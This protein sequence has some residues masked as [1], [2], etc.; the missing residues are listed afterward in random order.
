MTSEYNK[1]LSIYNK[2]S[3]FTQNYIDS[4]KSI[5]GKTELDQILGVNFIP[6]HQSE[7]IMGISTKIIEINEVESFALPI[8]VYNSRLWRGTFTKFHQLLYDHICMIKYAKQEKS[9][10]YVMDMNMNKHSDLD[11]AEI[12]GNTIYNTLLLYFR[13]GDINLAIIVIQLMRT[14]LFLITDF[15]NRLA[16]HQQRIIFKNKFK[17]LINKNIDINLFK[18]NFNPCDWYW[19]IYTLLSEDD[20]LILPLN[21]WDIIMGMITQPF[22]GK[23]CFT[24]DN[25]E[26]KLLKILL[27]NCFSYLSKINI[28]H[29]YTTKILIETIYTNCGEKFENHFVQNAFIIEILRNIFINPY[30]IKLCYGECVCLNIIL[31]NISY[32]RTI[33]TNLHGINTLN[34]ALS[35]NH[36]NKLSEKTFV[37]LVLQYFYSNSDKKKINFSM[38]YEPSSPTIIT[39]QVILQNNQF[40]KNSQKLVN[41]YCHYN[42]T[43]KY[44]NKP[45]VRHIH[46]SNNRN[47]FI[48]ILLPYIIQGSNIDIV[49]DL[50]TESIQY[51]LMGEKKLMQL[52]CKF[53]PIKCRIRDFYKDQLPNINIDQYHIYPLWLQ[54]IIKTKLKDI[55]PYNDNQNLEKKNIYTSIDNSIN[56]IAEFQNQLWY[57]SNSI[58]NTCLLCSNIKKKFINFHINHRVCISCYKKL[59]DKCPFC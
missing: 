41:K 17:T 36:Y 27:N 7:N 58:N 22:L 44:F 23:N 26:E 21:F 15:K 28:N 8:M 53:S 43:F 32:I 25:F 48:V 55:I 42:P 46:E 54:S 6:I 52:I 13:N 10:D 39:N 11:I 45:F 16:S 3:P 34:I 37:E 14:L 35:P 18:H 33:Y 19:C 38:L 59:N 57:L 56:I 50:I 29:C 51:G 24:F 49:K 5:N 9:G 40:H 31:K 2:L 47:K 4:I 12:Y 1:R 20:N 30:M